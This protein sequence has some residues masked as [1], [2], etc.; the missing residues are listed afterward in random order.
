DPR[1]L[2][3]RDHLLAA[4]RQLDALLPRELDPPLVL[5]LGGRGLPRGARA[6]ALPRGPAA[7]LARRLRRLLRGLGAA[8]PPGRA[9]RAPPGRRRARREHGRGAR[10][11]RPRA[12]LGRGRLPRGR[13]PLREARRERP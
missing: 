1:G 13:A 9:R 11:P 3:R 10:P 8:P 7:A 2:G 6:A 12:L 5:R 4:L